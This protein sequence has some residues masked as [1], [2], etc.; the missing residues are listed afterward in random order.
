MIASG[1][2]AAL[3]LAFVL[4]TAY[5][6]IGLFVL[7]PD[8]LFSIDAAV[9][10]L[11]AESLKATRFASMAIDYPARN[12]DPSLRFVPFGQPFV[13][14]HHGALQGVYP[15]AVALLN[16]AVPAGPAGLVVLS[17]LSALVVLVCVAHLAGADAA[18]V[19]TLVVGACSPFWA[20]AV[21]PWE[22]LPALALAT[23]AWVS[24]DG[25]SQIRSLLAGCL[26]GLAAA[27]RHE[28]ALLV[29]GL[30]IMCLR[31]AGWRHWIG[32]AGGVLAPLAAFAILDV[33]VYGR[34]PYS[35][36]AHAVHWIWPVIGGGS[37]VQPPEPIAISH[38]AEIVFGYWV[39]G[40]P[41]ASVVGGVVAALCASAWL[42]P[43]RL[44]QIAVI[45][46][47]SALSGLVARDL[48]AFAPQPD[49]VAGL[50][51]ASPILVFATLPARS[52]QST[53]RLLGLAA[54]GIF[55]CGLLLTGRHAGAQIGPR[56]LLAILPLAAL[57]ASDCLASYMR[58]RQV[59]DRVIAMLGVFLLVGSL[60]MQALVNFPT[61]ARLD[62]EESP[63]AQSLRS[64]AASV[65]VIDDIYLL[66]SVAFIY[67][68]TQVLLA[69]SQQGIADLSSRLAADSV[70]RVLLLQ[71][72]RRNL[73]MP[74]Y[75]ACTTVETA[76]TVLQDCS[77][78]QL[79][80]GAR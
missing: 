6:V 9:K 46:L 74:D 44:R 10:L 76:R 41:Y 61:L 4:T 77:L 26:L 52:S 79:P 17:A 66:K 8:A 78:G 36:L 14:E 34:P 5:C 80:S 62:R 7:D 50:L 56:F 54:L 22:H 39:L 55:V 28:F 49:F 38:Q 64:R 35:H 15:T 59:H 58:S 37:A 19:A 45:A 75:P 16:A 71:D 70:P 12:L 73:V 31:H 27:L 20:Y 69:S 68:L 29:P 3:A 33:A 25:R 18:V 60:G 43:G 51:R 21:L 1:R 67:P 23:V 48:I 2:G 30:A 65:I 42:M 11:Q 24:L 57:M 13:F 53:S 72:R 32:V 40:L 63:I 47:L